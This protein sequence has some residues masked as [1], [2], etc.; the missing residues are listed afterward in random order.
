M[1]I[2]S[3][4]WLE[5][6]RGKVVFGEGR[7][8]M[9][10]LIGQLGSM[11][12]AAKALNMSYRGVWARI[13][14][15][16]DRLGCKLIETSVGRGKDRGSRLTPEA[17]KL[18]E[19]FK[20]MTEKGLAYSDELFESIFEGRRQGIKSVAPVLAVVGPAGSG[21]TS[22]IGRL[23]A[24]WAPRGKR[25]GV[26]HLH[27]EE[28]QTAEPDQGLLRA[29]AQ[30]V[31]SFHLDHLVVDLPGP[32]DL[33]PE[34]VAANY[35]LGSD[36][37]LVESRRRLHLPSIEVFRLDR[38]KAPLTRRNRDLAAVVGDR[39]PDK[40]DW[41]HFDLDQVPALVDHLEKNVLG[42][43]QDQEKIK[44]V[45]DGRRVPMLPFVKEIIKNA[46]IGMVRSLKSCENAGDIDLNIRR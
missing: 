8:R 45:V 5:D 24:E 14:A 22:L 17:E 42:D 29:G 31:I 20:L 26:I 25:I 37:V 15:T 18:L 13:K 41:P 19:N 12:A 23:I 43:T 16:E 10:E 3:K 30:A 11:Q 40:P 7:R 44:L 1:R 33:T 32:S 35:A 21:K 27:E 36:L 34:S 6:D 9:L 2:K 4:F 39:P 28:I 46:V 38:Q